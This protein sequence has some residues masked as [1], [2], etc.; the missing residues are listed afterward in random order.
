MIQFF[1]KIKEKRIQKQIEKQHELELVQQRDLELAAI[2]RKK[3]DPN[4]SREET[5]SAFRECGLISGCRI[6]KDFR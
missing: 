5:M 2:I 3:E 1:K 4:V 6:K